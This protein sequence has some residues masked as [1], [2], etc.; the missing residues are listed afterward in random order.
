MKKLIGVVSVMYLLFIFLGCA[1]TQGMPG[2]IRDAQRRAPEDVLVGIG[3]A[4]LATTNQ[5]R[6]TAGSRARAEISRQMSTIVQDM[7]RDYTASSEVNNAAALA[8]QE[9]FTLSLS[10]SQLSGAAVV[11]EEQDKDGTWWSVVYLSK[12]NVAR[13]ISQA[14][15]AA[16]LTVPAMASFDAQQR[17]DEAF[18]KQRESEARGWW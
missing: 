10:R 7:I 18:E 6:T 3:S 1:T 4:N 16:R 11:A 8:F 14:Q 9:N 12:A 5:S 2:P 13:E 17:M 15:A